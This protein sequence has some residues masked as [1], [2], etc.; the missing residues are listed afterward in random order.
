M[1]ARNLAAAATALVCVL[2]LQ[3]Q[4]PCRAEPY[5]ATDTARRQLLTTDTASS[6]TY[7][8]AYHKEHAGSGL[9]GH[10]SAVASAGGRVVAVHPK[11]AVV[12]ARSAS[13]GFA[14]DVKASDSRILVRLEVACSSHTAC[15]SPAC[16]SMERC[17]VCVL[18]QC[19]TTTLGSRRS[20]G[21]TCL[22]RKYAAVHRRSPAQP[23]AHGDTATPRRPR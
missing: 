9:P 14:A 18:A 21:G 10:E 20:E 16:C 11:I 2:I 5:S 22:T 19:D 15:P 6:Q 4:A 7:L 8:V 17:P 23:T 3:L 13:E 12:V 1:H